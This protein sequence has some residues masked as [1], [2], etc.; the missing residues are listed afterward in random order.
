[1]KRFLI[2]LFAVVLVL[3]VIS[4]VRQH[5]AVRNSYNRYEIDWLPMRQWKVYCG[6]MGLI[7]SGP[8]P[9]NSSMASG[10]ELQFLFFRIDK[11]DGP[12]EIP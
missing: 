10:W 6:G 7:Y 8:L 4:F 12:G 5:H 3:S 9:Y 1:M 11:F 2:G